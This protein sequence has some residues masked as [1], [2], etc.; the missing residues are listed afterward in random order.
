MHVLLENLLRKLNWG[1]RRRISDQLQ[2]QLELLR[3]GVPATATVLK[4]LQEGNAL[5]GFVVLQLWVTMKVQ[6][7]LEH[8]TMRT[9][10]RKDSLPAEGQTIHIRYS[11][12]DLT[13]LLIV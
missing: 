13:R 9:V 6:G 4:V 11:P 7:H 10:A 3:T 12:A 8:H 1:R 2:G 5:Q